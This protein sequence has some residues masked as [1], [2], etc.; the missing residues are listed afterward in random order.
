MLMKPT[1]LPLRPFDADAV[2]LAAVT[3]EERELQHAYRCG[4]YRFY[5]ADRALLYVGI[6]RNLADRWNWHRCKTDWYSRARYVALSFYPD[7]HDAFRAEASAIRAQNPLFNVLRCKPARSK[8]DRVDDS[9]YAPPL[10]RLPEE[11]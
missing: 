1:H 2:W 5:D 9:L 11:D 7:R 6:S 3:N 4:L 8:K 10:A